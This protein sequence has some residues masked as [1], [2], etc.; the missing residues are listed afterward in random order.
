[1]EGGGT[2]SEREANERYWWSKIR[3]ALKAGDVE[4]AERFLQHDD[5]EME[6]T[7]RCRV[8]DTFTAGCIALG[9]PAQP[10]QE[11]NHD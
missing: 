8:A 2:V 11:K 5:K 7:L 10:E 6:N 3:Q 4:N 9:D 1:M